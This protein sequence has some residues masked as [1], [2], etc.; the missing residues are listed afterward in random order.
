METTAP[1]PGRIRHF[2]EEAQ[3]ARDAAQG[4]PPGEKRRQCLAFAHAYERL[5]ESYARRT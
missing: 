4:L 1:L 2:R 3:K 5:A